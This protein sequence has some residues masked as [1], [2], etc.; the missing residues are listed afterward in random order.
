MLMVIL[1]LRRRHWLLQKSLWFPNSSGRRGP[2]HPPVWEQE[3]DRMVLGPGSGGGNA[4]AFFAALCPGEEPGGQRLP[5]PWAWSFGC[6]PSHWGGLLI[7][8]VAPATLH[9]KAVGGDGMSK[10]KQGDKKAE[11]G[12]ARNSTGQGEIPGASDGGGGS[13][14]RKVR[15][16]PESIYPGVAFPRPPPTQPRR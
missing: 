5:R 6:V 9:C 10:G 11:I 12:Q 3:Q 15:T 16:S 1:E 7:I 8:G 14:W 4:P 13:G 2:K